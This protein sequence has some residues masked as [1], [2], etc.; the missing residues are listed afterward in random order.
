VNKASGA[1]LQKI[2]YGEYQILIVPTHLPIDVNGG[3]LK[4]YHNIVFKIDINT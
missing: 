4:P 2:Q 3:G 1:K